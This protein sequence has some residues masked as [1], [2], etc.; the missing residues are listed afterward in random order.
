MLWS[1]VDVPCLDTGL[2]QSPIF[3]MSGMG[4]GEAP[5]MHSKHTF[6]QKRYDYVLNI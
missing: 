3:D 2:K 1:K 4:L 5:K 6:V